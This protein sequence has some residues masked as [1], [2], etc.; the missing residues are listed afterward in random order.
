MRDL[1]AQIAKGN[2]QWGT[3]HNVTEKCSR[4]GATV[5]AGTGAHRDYDTYCDAC[6]KTKGYET[7]AYLKSKRY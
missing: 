6:C 4:C 1:E 5:P 2:E 3:R 7:D